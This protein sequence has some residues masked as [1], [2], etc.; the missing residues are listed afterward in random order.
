LG[1]ENFQD[2]KLIRLTFDDRVHQSAEIA[3]NHLTQLSETSEPYSPCLL[4]D[5]DR[6][7]RS[8]LTRGAVGAWARTIGSVKG[9]Q[10]LDLLANVSGARFVVTRRSLM[11]DAL[12]IK[13]RV[14]RP[15]GFFGIHNEMAL[16]WL[17]PRLGKNWLSCAGVLPGVIGVPSFLLRFPCQPLLPC[18][19]RCL[20]VK[21][22]AQ[23]ISASRCHDERT[24]TNRRQF[25]IFQRTAIAW[26]S[27]RYSLRRRRC[28]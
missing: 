18:Y 13:E 10:V 25:I 3:I 6:H 2:V 4:R 19:R 24:E 17:S 27:S 12:L 21:R 7:D 5:E 16:C 26:T 15:L 28:T 9:S 1:E 22:G 8:I 14:V 23:S 20:V 11:T